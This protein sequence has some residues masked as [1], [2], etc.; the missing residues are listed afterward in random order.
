MQYCGLRCG[1]GAPHRAGGALGARYS[2]GIILK[3]YVKTK[4]YFGH[5]EFYACYINKDS[6]VNV[7]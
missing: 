2:A 3:Q 7:M 5:L 1:A 4:N 6:Y